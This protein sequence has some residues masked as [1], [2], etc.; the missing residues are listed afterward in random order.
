M[1]C[2]RLLDSASDSLIMTGNCILHDAAS[3]DLTL[4]RCMDGERL[5]T[6]VRIIELRSELRRL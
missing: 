2:V 1:V 4:V 6:S 3:E 5:Q